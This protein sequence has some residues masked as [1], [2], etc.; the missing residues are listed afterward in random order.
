M[1]DKLVVSKLLLQ[2]KNGILMHPEYTVTDEIIHH[3]YVN[4]PIFNK[5]VDLIC[6]YFNPS[7]MSYNEKVEFIFN[8]L[9]TVSHIY[10]SK[11]ILVRITDGISVNFYPEKDKWKDNLN[12]ETYFGSVKDFVFWVQGRSNQ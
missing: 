6:S 8:N 11:T 5:T 2:F 10:D 7:P 9:T 12:N 4:D 3:N 1:E